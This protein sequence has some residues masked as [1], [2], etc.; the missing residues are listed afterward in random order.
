MKPR[1][2]VCIVNQ[3]ASKRR[4]ARILDEMD[5]E[6]GLA[7]AAIVPPG[8]EGADGLFWFCA[9]GDEDAEVLAYIQSF[10]VRSRRVSSVAHIRELAIMLV[11]AV[12]AGR[13]ESSRDT[14][15]LSRPN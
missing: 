9:P 2:M 15:P 6:L 1:I 13:G 4:V 11:D 14:E 8:T 10:N 5:E 12:R 3:F 7:G